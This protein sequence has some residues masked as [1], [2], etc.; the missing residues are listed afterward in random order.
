MTNSAHQ[1]LIIDQFSRQAIPFA[2]IPGHHD[3][4]QLL[5]EMVG[6]GPDDTVLDVACGPGIVAS[7]FA[8]RSKA[9]TGI[10]LTPAMIEQAKRHQQEQGLTNLAWELGD[11]GRLPFADDSFSIVVTRYSFH[12]LLHPAQALAEMIRVCR[13][14]GRVLVADVALPPEKAAAYD[15][16]EILR[17]PSHTHA[18]T[19]PEF[20]ALFAGSGLVD[21]RQAA[22]GVELKLEA[23]LKASFPKEG[24]E[25]KVRELVSFDIGTDA[26]GIAARREEGEVVYTVPI[27]VLAGDKAR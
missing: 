18:L 4:V 9:V 6:A 13:P 21:C 16:L 1:D 26:L 5:I 19:V 20:E 8:R 14:G 11:I 22:Y 24:D 23:T 2:K 25:E 15:R 17:D 7:E 12:H 10:D 3:S 27:A